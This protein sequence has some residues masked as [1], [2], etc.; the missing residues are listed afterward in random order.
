MAQ[1][2]WMAELLPSNIADWDHPGILQPSGVVHRVGLSYEDDYDS[3]VVWSDR[4]ADF[5]A[6]PG[7]EKTTGLVIG[8]WWEL[9]DGN[10][11]VDE[12]VESLV[13]AAPQL[14]NLRALFVGDIMSEESEISWIEQDD[15]SPLLSAFPNLQHFAIR[16]A[17]GLSLGSCQ[18]AQ[19]KTLVI[20]SGGLAN[21]VVQEIFQGKLPALEHL[22]LW[23]GSDWY[24][25]DVTLTDLEPLLNGEL[26][27]QLKVLAL[28]DCSF[29][30]DLAIALSQAPIINRIE[31]LDLSLGNLGDEGAKALLACPAIKQLKLLD[32][33]YHFIDS[34]LAQQF[35]QLGIEVDISEP[36]D[37][38]R[39]DRRYIA[40]SE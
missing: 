31:I 3:K 34:E 36:Q 40:V 14:P 2:P 29:A 5:L 35:K 17:N 28:R 12:V 30:D 11:P 26:F 33:H 37:P 7:V 39:H 8:T 22:E 9:D 16:G 4:F 15:L 13:S 38:N 1:L 23:L 32:L 27:P 19:L 24:G 10:G 25:G 20:Q 6:L 18:H 21:R